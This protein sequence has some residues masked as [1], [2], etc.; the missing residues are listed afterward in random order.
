MDSSKQ[1]SITF[2]KGLR[3]VHDTTIEYTLTYDDFCEKFMV[4]LDDESPEAF[5]TRSQQIWLNLL[6][7]QT[8]PRFSRVPFIDLGTEEGECDWDDELWDGGGEESPDDE[9][10]DEVWDMITDLKGN[11]AFKEDQR[12]KRADALAEDLKRQE[13]RLA[14]LKREEAERQARLKR[15]EAERAER[16]KREEEERQARARL[17]KEER[18]AIL[19]KEVERLQ[20]D[21]S[22]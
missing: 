14:R 19:R 3:V 13:E 2:Q 12:Q 11:E 9:C 10:F 20:A 6:A 16:L 7:K 21:L 5:S 18:L 15:E 22:V 8:K 17:V 4:R 1:H